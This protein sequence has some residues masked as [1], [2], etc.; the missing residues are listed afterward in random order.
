VGDGM[1]LVS[2]TDARSQAAWLAPA[3]GVLALAG[4]A[5]LARRSVEARRFL[6][7]PAAVVLCH[8]LS[9]LV[10]PRL[11]LPERYVAYAVPA[12]ALVA[13]P[14]ALGGLAHETRRSLRA[15]PWLQNALV[16]L[17]L[18][19]HGVNWSGFTIR[20]PTAERR[21]D[22]FIAELPQSTLIAAFP[23]EISDSIPYLARRSVYLAHETHM[24]FH[25]GYTELMRTRARTLFHAYFTGSVDVLRE[26]REREGVTHLLVRRAD[27]RAPPAYF[28]PFDVDIARDF[29]EGRARGFAALRLA[30]ALA[31]FQSDELELLDLSRL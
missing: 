4:C 14:S 28:A 18:G 10:E 17:L 8:T 5:W 20:V 29:A 15:L 16:L 23:S 12:L 6:L 3:L 9:L 11:F 27:F 21:L 22:R 26:L 13:L 24:P 30:P 25:T 2:L 7:L 31:V 1:P 19:A